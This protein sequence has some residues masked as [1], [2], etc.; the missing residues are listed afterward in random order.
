MTFNKI[1]HRCIE[2][3]YI[4]ITFISDSNISDFCFQ[5]KLIHFIMKKL[6][7]SIVVLFM[8]CALAFSQEKAKSE[9]VD[10]RWEVGLN[11]G[12][13]NFAGEYNMAKVSRFNHFNFW[14]SDKDFG[15]G[16]SVKKNFS[17]VFAL[18]LGW[19]YTN[20]T[21]SW[22]WFQ[23]GPKQDFK[24]E[25]N[26]YDLN[27]V[28]NLS[29]LLSKS[30]MDRKFYWYA[31][32]G[33]GATHV[34]K[35][36]GEIAVNDNNWKFPTIPI[37]LGVAYRLNDNVKLNIGTQWSFV[38]T[39]K[40]D[41]YDALVPSDAS[42]KVGDVWGSKL[43]THAGIS[44]SIGKKKKPEPVIE[45]PVKAPEPKPVPDVKPAPA[46][47]PPPPPPPPPVEPVK[48]KV[49]GNVYK[50]LFGLNFA[51]DKWNLDSQSSTEL[52][53]LVKDM[54]ENPTVDVEIKSHSDSRGSASY[55]MLLSE[56]RGK[57]VSDYLI[58]KGISPS[59]IKSLAYGETQLLNK[60]ADG[61][62]CTA[63]EHAANRRSEATLVI[64]KKE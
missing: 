53:R 55:N 25:V 24:T 52:D 16:A 40:L 7:L 48:P 57:S 50:I 45:T 41:G 42:A 26:E 36:A 8:C 6:S 10:K 12:L 11:M 44:F 20:L 18:E 63:A 30:K 59:R 54:I 33:L 43:Y 56:K 15:F 13:A 60:C 28:W 22:T 2:I 51:F 9:P 32:I 49:V 39:N 3:P 58:S 37:G 61:V 4:S 1:F 31:K 23:G 34:W 14:N 27:T 35:K 19:N 29:N 5:E 46:P 38:N 17:H 62:P 47:A 64:L 21:G